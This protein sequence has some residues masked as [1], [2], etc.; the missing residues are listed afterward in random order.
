M[1]VVTLVT[2]VYVSKP[3]ALASISSALD[4]RITPG[5]PGENVIALPGG[6]RISLEVPKF[7]E[8]L[9]VTLDIHGLNEDELSAASDQIMSDLRQKLNWSVSRVG[10]DR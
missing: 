9:P 4:G 3:Q 7:G 1:A 5:G 6:V 2:D 8:D 10:G